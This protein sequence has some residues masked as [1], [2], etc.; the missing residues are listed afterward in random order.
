MRVDAIALSATGRLGEASTRY[1][2]L[3]RALL[4]DERGARDPDVVDAAADLAALRVTSGLMAEAR[5]L[6]DWVDG[7]PTP[8]S[9][10]RSPRSNAAL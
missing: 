10:L 8:A 1:D 7:S 3:D 4:D 5:R 2:G 6:V 9:A